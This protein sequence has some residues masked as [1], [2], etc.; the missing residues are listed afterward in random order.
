VSPHSDEH[1]PVSKPRFE[2]LAVLG[3]G[4]LGGSVALAA[5]RAGLAKQVAGAGRRKAPLELAVR[6]GIV[7]EAGDAASAAAGADLVV[8]ASPVSSMPELLESIASELEPGAIVTDVGSVKGRLSE[9]LPAL[10]PAGVHYVGSHPM[11]GSH[12]RGVENVDADLFAGSCCVLTPVPGSDAGVVDRLIGFWQAVGA[13]VVVRKPDEHDADVAWVSH[14][15]HLLAFAFA[16]AFAEAPESAAIMRGGGFRDFTRIA[17][18]DS[19]LWGDIL[20]AN[21]KALVAPLQA[22]GRSLEEVT[23]VLEGGDPDVLERFLAASRQRLLHIESVT[24]ESH[25]DPDLE[26]TRQG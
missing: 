16:H 3:L 22:F 8:L 17:H 1:P 21:K 24:D 2:R 25:Q 13:R 6:R 10:L 7:D 9:V 4:L 26:E 12:L 20:A 5:K 15:P 23:R 18:S 11:A 14:A 19:E